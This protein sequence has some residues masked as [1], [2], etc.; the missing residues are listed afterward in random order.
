MSCMHEKTSVWLLT[1]VVDVEL[2]EESVHLSR[3]LAIGGLRGRHQV[4]AARHRAGL[5]RRSNAV[6]R[7]T[8][9]A[10]RN[11]LDELLGRQTLRAAEVA[12]A[13]AFDH[14]LVDDRA[15]VRRELRDRARLALQGLG[16]GHRAD[17]GLDHTELHM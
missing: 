3:G 13:L 4:T 2:F 11:N 5:G 10:L 14:A 16:V 6:C 1:V 15:E 17:K 7:I 8:F 9:E 12:S